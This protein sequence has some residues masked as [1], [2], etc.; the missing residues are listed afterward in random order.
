MKKIAISKFKA[1]CLGV[2]EEVRK[3]RHPVLVTRFGKPVAEIVPPSAS[4]SRKRVLGAREDKGKILGDLVR[5]NPW[6]DEERAG[7]NGKR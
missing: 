3:T 5:A 4:P 7:R 6:L 2:L 1:T